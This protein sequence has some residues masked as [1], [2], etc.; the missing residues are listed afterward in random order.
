MLAFTG[1]DSWS[2]S[3][4]PEPPNQ[5]AALFSFWPDDTFS[6]ERSPQEEEEDSEEERREGRRRFLTDSRVTACFVWHFY[7]RGGPIF[8]LHTLGLIHR[9]L[10]QRGIKMKRL[11]FFWNDIL[12]L[13][14]II[15]SSRWLRPPYS[16]DSPAFDT[17]I[18]HFSIEDRREASERASERATMR[19][20]LLGFCCR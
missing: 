1:L 7:P 18:V 13:A 10:P 5:R 12:P 14:Y 17:I 20:C 16:A 2:P 4:P 8:I 15:R 6:V 3:L 19:R 11:L 9:S